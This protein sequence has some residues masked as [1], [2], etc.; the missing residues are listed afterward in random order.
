M[1][2]EK[3][4]DHQGRRIERT[5][6]TSASPDRVWQAWADPE[7]LAQWFADRA[8][9]VAMPGGTLTWSFEKFGAFPYEVFAAEP[10]ERLVLTG[11]PPGRPRFYTAL[12]WDQIDGVLELMAFSAG[13]GANRVEGGKALCLRAFGWDLD[14]ARASAIE[15]NLDAALTRLTAVLPRGS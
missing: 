2:E 10:G 3:K 6:R 5:I 15:R 4:V 1:H 8:S 11:A 12:T 9:G 14:D 7:K 13:P